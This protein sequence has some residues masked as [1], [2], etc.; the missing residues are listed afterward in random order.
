MKTKLTRLSLR[1]AAL[2]G[3]GPLAAA[4]LLG[5]MTALAQPQDPLRTP[6][7]LQGLEGDVKSLRGVATRHRD[8]IRLVSESLRDN[9]SQRDAGLALTVA[10]AML[11]GGAAAFAWH[12]SRRL[13]VPQAGTSWFGSIAAPAY[14]DEYLVD[15]EPAAGAPLARPTEVAAPVAPARPHGGSGAPAMPSMAAPAAL[16][17]IE[18]SL[19]DAASAGTPAAA[20][21]SVQT[22]DFKV[23]ALHGTQQQAEFFGS[24][25]QSDEAL[26]VLTGY[27]EESGEQPV[28]VFLE[29]F[30]IYHGTGQRSEYEQLQSR[31]RRIFRL[32]VAD[33][34]DYQEDQSELDLY[35]MAVARIATAWPSKE[36][37]QVIEDLLF[38][39]PATPRQLLSLRA[40]RDL[41]WLHGLGQ[42][43][44]HG[45]GAPAG[46]Q[47]PGGGGLS[48]ADIL[49]WAADAQHDPSGLSIERLHA[50]E[51]AS[52]SEAFA[53]DVDLNAV[54][55]LA[56]RAAE[57]AAPTEPAP[58][59]S[60]DE[61]NAFDQVMESVSRKRP[62]FSPR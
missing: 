7:R 3:C 34:D 1:V 47:L 30:R 6:Q 23:D 12:R 21:P 20:A 2:I 37:Q 8:E 28:L 53:V 9:R 17:P 39:K 61:M 25:G 48:D 40:C 11:T 32:E 57:P 29:L 22:H 15:D 36:S 49:P 58:L 55:S 18:F 52:G 59:A 4:L 62:G 45:R 43:I 51:V 50:V 10:L 16:A 41:L 46:L 54:H 31:F 44:V 14:G 13:R 26:A 27:L 60:P 42:E 56:A 38:S 33:F 24:L 35:P 5:P 19:P